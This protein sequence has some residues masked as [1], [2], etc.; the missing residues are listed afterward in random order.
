MKIAFIGLGIMGSNMASNLAKNNVNLT[1]YNRT[2]KDFETFG[3]S[4]ITIVDSIKNAVK[5]ADIVFSMLS[6]PQVVEDVFF[7]DEGAL[8]SMKKNAI[9]A[10][11]TTVNPS[12]S[13][14]AFR[15]AEKYDIRFLDT[16]VS[17]S[18]I[19]AKNAELLLIYLGDT[20]SV[21]CDVTKNPFLF[22]QFP[23]STLLLS[24]FLFRS[25]FK[26][27]HIHFPYLH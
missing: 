22:Q 3:N 24:S 20:E 25:I 2:P 10:D 16:P 4:N 8:N 5:D 6:T 14:I 18:K 23:F 7:G 21:M 11:C 13:S 12:F 17:G 19:P 26:R 15:V 27:L 9:W 1:V